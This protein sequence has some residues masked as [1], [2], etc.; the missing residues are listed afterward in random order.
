MKTEGYLPNDWSKNPP[1]TVE[2]STDSTSI[3]ILNQKKNT[4]RLDDDK[5]KEGIDKRFE[6]NRGAFTGGPMDEEEVKNRLLD[7]EDKAESGDIK[8]DEDGRR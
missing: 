6:F 7:F 1:K 3:D 4:T 8:D 5:P 2:N